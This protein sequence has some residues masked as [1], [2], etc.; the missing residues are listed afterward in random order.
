MIFTK[1]LEEITVTESSDIILSCETNKPVETLEWFHE[2][3]PIKSGDRYEL[4]SE[5][6]I[7]TLTI[8]DSVLSDAGKYKAVADDDVET[9]ANLH[10]DGNISLFYP[11]I[12]KITIFLYL[13]LPA[14]FTKA[15]QEMNIIEKEPVTLECETNK[16]TNNVEWAKDGEKIKSSKRHKRVSKGRHHLLHILDTIPEDEGEYEASVGNEKTTARLNVQGRCS[17]LC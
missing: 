2:D 3:K 8:K 17:K 9:I 15:L 1:P 7:Y 4:D 14:I 11:S 12:N 13:E 10:L 16:P 5:D 6:T